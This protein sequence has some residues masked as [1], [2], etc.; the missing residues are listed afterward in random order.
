M[1]FLSTI[2]E[3]FAQ[4]PVAGT[5]L[6]VFV[7]GYALFLVVREVVE[8]FIERKKEASTVKQSMTQEEIQRY[9]SYCNKNKK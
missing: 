6:V 8:F 4:M 5:L 3:S 1:S 9:I 7:L 2:A